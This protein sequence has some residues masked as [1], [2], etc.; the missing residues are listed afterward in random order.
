M[1]SDVNCPVCGANGTAQAND[2][3]A[4]SVAT[5]PAAVA[6]SVPRAAMRVATTATMPPPAASIPSAP[7]GVAQQ[8]AP[9]NAQVDFTRAI[10]EARAKVF[11]GDTRQQAIVCLVGHGVNHS[12]ASNIVDGLMK[13]RAAAIRAN[14]IR[15]IFLGIGY[16]CVPIISLLIFLRIGFLP[17][18]LFAVTVMIGLWGAWMVIKGCFMT[19]APKAEAGDVANQ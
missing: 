1:P 7:P 10:N 3:I 17:I 18:K 16:M 4:R 14:G 19:V 15:K 5:Q 6:I 13:A 8:N 12:E 2:L 9:A 11:W